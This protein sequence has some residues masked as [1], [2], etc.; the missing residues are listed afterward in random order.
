MNKKSNRNTN[1]ILAGMG[2]DKSQNG[3]K[4]VKNNSPA[5]GELIYSSTHSLW[6]A[7]GIVLSVHVWQ[8]ISPSAETL[9][10]AHAFT[11]P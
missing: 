8:V 10:F 7:F 3:V 9:L 6:S 4:E 1:V 2:L 11:P 5:R